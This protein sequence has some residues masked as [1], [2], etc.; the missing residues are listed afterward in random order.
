MKTVNWRSL[1]SDTQST[2]LSAWKNA[3]KTYKPADAP[4]GMDGLYR[5]HFSGIKYKSGGYKPRNRKNT[6]RRKNTRKRKKS[7]KKRNKSTKRKNTRRRK[8]TSRRK[9]R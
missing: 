6:R 4:E 1:D 3:E 5:M 2:L 9:R 8:T 7:T